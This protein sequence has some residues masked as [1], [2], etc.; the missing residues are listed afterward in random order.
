MAPSTHTMQTVG[1]WLQ[2]MKKAMALTY[3]ATLASTTTNVVASFAALF[4]YHPGIGQRRTPNQNNRGGLVPVVNKH[5]FRSNCLSYSSSTLATKKR[6]IAGWMSMLHDNDDDVSTTTSA[7]RTEQRRIDMTTATAEAAVKQ[8]SI[9]ELLTI[10]D[11]WEVRY[12]PYATRELLTT[13]LLR[14]N[15]N[16]RNGM[17]TAVGGSTTIMDDNARH[18]DHIH[19]ASKLESTADN[20][21]DDDRTTSSSKQRSDDQQVGNTR[22]RRSSSRRRRRNDTNNNIRS[23]E[24]N[25]GR[26]YHSDVTSYYTN[27]NNGL[28]PVFNMGFVETSR[29]AS[30]LVTDAIVDSTIGGGGGRKGSGSG[31]SSS[32]TNSRSGASVDDMD[33]T[34]GQRR[35][36][37]RSRRQRRGRNNVLDVDVIN[38]SPRQRVVTD[39]RNEGREVNDANEDR[40]RN[41]RQQCTDINEPPPRKGNVDHYHAILSSNEGVSTRSS[42]H[43]RIIR[44]EKME[45]RLLPKKVYGLYQPNSSINKELAKQDE[46]SHH[47]QQQQQQQQRWK[48][49]LRHKFDI[50]LGLEAES[51]RTQIESMDDRRKHV[52]RRRLANEFNNNDEQHLG[53]SLRRD[54]SPLVVVVEPNNR[55]ARMRNRARRAKT[56]EQRISSSSSSMIPLSSKTKTTIESSPN[57]S[58]RLDEVPFWRD[59]GSIASLLFDTR[60]SLSYSVTGVGN[61]RHP[62]RGKFSLEQLLLSPFGREHTVTSLFLYCSRSAITAFGSLCRWAGV[63]G[64]IPQPIVVLT[65]IATVLSSR[66]GSRVMSLVLTLLAMRLVGEFIHGSLNGNE[67][68]EDEYDRDSHN[69]KK[70]IVK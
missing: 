20:N 21:N 44:N 42:S 64:T 65:V 17:S 38:Y 49:R 16:I 24:S 68:W 31:R 2:G 58:R 41:K 12:P 30:R 39:E 8:M 19:R 35:Q 56:D 55:R 32:A 22:Q 18:H 27:N 63:R 54:D 7:T 11:T 60:S 26:H 15:N 23:I 52:L 37:N 62:R 29:I 14:Y 10:L 69:W 46:E 13:I 25:N 33:G 6:S 9:N 28:L 57:P 5:L 47:E 59:T 40:R 70:K 34:I 43:R 53:V 3:A 1:D 61:A 66:V 50:V 4:A 36:Q 67:F 45:D 51:L 48:D